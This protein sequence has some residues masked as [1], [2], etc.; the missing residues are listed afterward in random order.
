M[1]NTIVDACRYVL[2]D[3]GEAQTS[4]RRSSIMME[5]KLWRASESQVRVALERDSAGIPTVLGRHG[6][7]ARAERRFDQVG[8]SVQAVGVLNA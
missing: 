4:Y 2:E 3:Q 5:V 7:Q 1:I 6:A 8:R